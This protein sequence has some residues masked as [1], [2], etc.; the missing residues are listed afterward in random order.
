MAYELHCL[1]QGKNIG[2][3]R[4]MCGPKEMEV[5]GSWKELYNGELH[6]LY[7]AK[8]HWGE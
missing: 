2:W 8:H 5:T 4:T 1:N 7:F 6:N 3:P